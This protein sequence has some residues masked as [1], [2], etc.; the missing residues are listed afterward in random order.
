M[1]AFL[2]LQLL[3]VGITRGT[4]EV[5]RTSPPGASREVPRVPLLLLAGFSRPAWSLGPPGT[6]I[7]TCFFSAKLCLFS[8][9]SSVLLVFKILFTFSFIIL[10]LGVALAP[11]SR[12]SLLFVFLSRGA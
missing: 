5:A 10:A 7:L 12:V 4:V 2:A 1:V 9:F 6:I 8:G 3:G 11:S